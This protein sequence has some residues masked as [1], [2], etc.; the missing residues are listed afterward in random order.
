MTENFLKT[1]IRKIIFVR[2]KAEFKKSLRI[3]NLNTQ[4][5]LDISVY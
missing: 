2:L 3:K 5:Y 1:K 4:F